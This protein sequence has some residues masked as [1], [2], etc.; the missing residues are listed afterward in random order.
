MKKDKNI[1][2]AY[3]AALSR[4]KHLFSKEPKEQQATMRHAPNPS[5]RA[6]DYL[7]LPRLL[8]A[9]QGLILS[10]RKGIRQ[11][12][13]SKKHISCLGV[14]HCSL[15][16]KYLMHLLLELKSLEKTRNVK[17]LY[18]KEHLLAT[19]NFQNMGKEMNEWMT[20]Y[21]AN[22]I[23]IIPEEKPKEANDIPWEE[24]VRQKEER[25][26]LVTRVI[27]YLLD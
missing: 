22:K 5:R 10:A 7:K 27:K 2:N 9:K 3:G 23:K 20:S 24:Y 16:P 1:S 19:R 21:L 18:L 14:S 4:V 11:D 12:W 26:F 15:S 6:Y 13:W 8:A 25:Q 17:K